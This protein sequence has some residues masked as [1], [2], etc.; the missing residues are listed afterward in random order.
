[1]RF[2][3]TLVITDPCYFV[4]ESD[5]NHVIDDGELYLNDLVSC[6]M[7]AADTGFGDWN[8]V[9][10]DMKTNSQIG[11]FAADAGMVCITTLENIARYDPSKVEHLKE[12]PRCCFI[13][14]DFIGE[15]WF[16]RDFESNTVVHTYG[17]HNL[18]GGMLYVSE[19]ALQE[20]EE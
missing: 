6:P 3:G 17:S 2:E 12:I 18:W 19:S 15:A 1:M 11:E 5:W 16:T 10:L 9:V 13:L 7:L 20:E 14:P 4:T 8:C